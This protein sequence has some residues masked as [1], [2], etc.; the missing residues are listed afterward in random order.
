MNKVIYIGE[1][2]LAFTHMKIYEV[3][4]KT[5]K[6]RTAYVQKYVITDSGKLTSLSIYKDGY[7]IGL[8]EWRA[9]QINQILNE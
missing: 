1:T 6:R 3:H 7:F 2:N 8:D 9:Q 5:S 4:D